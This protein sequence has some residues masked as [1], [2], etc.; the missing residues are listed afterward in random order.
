MSSS[1]YWKGQLDYY[2]SNPPKKAESYY[3]QSFVDK[4]N[5]AQRNIDNLVKEKDKSYAATGQAQDE[6]KA[7]QGSMS[8]YEEVY[9][10][11]KSEFGVEEHHDNYEKSKKALALAESTLSALPS[12]INSASN[13]VLTQQQRE[14]RYNTLSD[15]FMKNRDIKAEN[16][17]RYE[18]VWRQARENQS[19]YASAEMASQWGK[20][21]DYNT[22]WLRSLDEYAKAQEALTQGETELRNWKSDYRSWQYN[23]WSYENTIWLKNY[24]SAL[25]RYEEALDTELAAFQAQQQ[26]EA[27]DRQARYAYEQ[28]QRKEKLAQSLVNSYYNSKKAKSDVYQ[29]YLGLPSLNWW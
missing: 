28:Q 22:A 20:L 18:D 16:V 19:A 25:A 23:Q 7:F 14:A 5:E 11:S 6:Y 21:G 27:A 13:R 10:Q 1:A 9:T 12:S 17:S 3:N 24:E 26:M 4:I 8:T 29:Q 15:R 2:K